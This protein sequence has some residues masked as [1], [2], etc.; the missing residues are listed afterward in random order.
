MASET[1]VIEVTAALMRTHIGVE[2]L[3]NRK[4]R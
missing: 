4:R 1:E 2:L 3:R